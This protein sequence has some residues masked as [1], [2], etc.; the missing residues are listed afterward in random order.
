MKPISADAVKK[1]QM[2]HPSVS[3]QTRVGVNVVPDAYS[4][5]ERSSV[6]RPNQD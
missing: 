6:W 2:I 1:T 3:A 4:V 5:C